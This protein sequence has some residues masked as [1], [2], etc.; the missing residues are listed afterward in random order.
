MASYN[1]KTFT[2]PESLKEMDPTV[3]RALFLRFEGFF[4]DNGLNLQTTLAC[5]LPYEEIA[6]LLLTTPE[7]AQDLA[8]TLYIID[9]LNS[10]RWYDELAEAAQ[11]LGM[12]VPEDM[13][14]ADLATLVWLKDPVL[15]QRLHAST[16]LH[17]QR[18]FDYFHTHFLDSEWQGPEAK[19]IAEIET[20]LAKWF[21]QNQRGDGCRV[22]HFHREGVHWFLVWHGQP[23]RRE[24][25]VVEGKPGSV[26][27]RPEK[28]DVLGILPPEGSLKIHAGRA[29]DVTMYRDLMSYFF[30]PDDET[31]QITSRYSLDPLK[32]LGE[33]ALV[34]SDVD[35]LHKIKL[36]EVQ[37]NW[38][39]PEGEVEIRKARDVF[40]A[41]QQAN[42]GLPEDPEIVSAKFGVAFHGGKR[43]RSVTLRPPNVVQYTRDPD[44][45]PIEDWLRKRGFYSE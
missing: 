21:R 44:S 26:V 13:A 32:I 31:F 9:E 43:S 15:A 25:S 7:D 6:K 12:S 36:R 40:A 1:P 42:R 5:E 20:D 29:K 35:G 3:L 34:C 11:S 23:F 17:R 27:Y 38:G 33:E 16:Y 2:K 41:S 10:D 18:R 4:L 28:Y 24:G 19:E 30:L 37:F 39:G 22:F 14:P 45:A 8:G